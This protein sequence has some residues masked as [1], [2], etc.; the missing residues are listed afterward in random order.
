M[1]EINSN[2]P[3]KPLCKQLTSKDL[4][5]RGHLR[6][7]LQ[8]L[9]D[10]D[11]LRWAAPRLHQAFQCSCG[12]QSGAL[13]T[14]QARAGPHGTK[15]LP[16]PTCRPCRRRGTKNRS[17]TGDVYKPD[18]AHACQPLYGG[19]RLE[20][21]ASLLSLCSLPALT[22]L[23][24]LQSINLLCPQQG[25]SFRTFFISQGNF[26]PVLC[27]PIIQACPWFLLGRTEQNFS[28]KFPALSRHKEKWLLKKRE[29][30]SHYMY[31]QPP[32]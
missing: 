22:G 1:L 13:S 9:R 3:S 15:G 21:Q 7:H 11:L 12:R 27:M 23:A 25:I 29:A 4:G 17:K 28:E 8:K 6:R 32:Y 2:E 20:N 16:S 31:V 14:G 24:P 30:N 19:S 18:L 26:L 10:N 5:Q